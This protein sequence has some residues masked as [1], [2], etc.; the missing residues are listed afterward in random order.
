MSLFGVTAPCATPTA[1]KQIAIRPDAC[2][3]P[4]PVEIS[5]YVV[6]Q[7]QV[8]NRFYFYTTPYEIIDESHIP[9][10]LYDI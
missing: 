8:L 3:N 9:K 4:I 6:P 10:D 7:Y 2:G 5:T 1:C